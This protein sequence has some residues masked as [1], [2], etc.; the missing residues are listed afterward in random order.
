MS[1]F[2]ELIKN[3][4]KT[5]DYMRDF[6]VF[7]YKTRS[8]FQL[9]SPRTYDN[10]KRRIESWLGDLIQFD[11]TKK[12][13]QVSISLDSRQLSTNP[14]YKAYKSKSF[15]N[16]DIKLHFFLLDLLNGSEPLSV[17]DI[18]D[19][20]CNTY[21]EY[22]EPQTI[23]LKLREYVSEGIISQTKCGKAY[24]YKLSEM[25]PDTLCSRYKDFPEMLGFFSEVAP[26]GVVGSFL[27]DQLNLKNGTF[28]FKHPFIVHTLEDNILLQLIKAID[29]KRV[30]E[31]VNFSKKLKQTIIRATPLKIYVST[32]TGRRYVVMYLPF[33]KRFT[34]FRLDNIKSVKALETDDNFDEYT[35]NLHKNAPMCWGVSFGTVRCSEQS[36][37]FRMIL[38]IDEKNERDVLERLLREKRNGMVERIDKNTFAYSTSIFDTNEMM[39]WV[40]TFIG[41]IVSLEGANLPV[42]QK[43]HHDIERMKHL[44]EEV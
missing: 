31:I 26:F 37:S 38:H 29:E 27:M 10:E 40:K 5:R 32:Q 25:F 41:R 39:N 28:I 22:F 14:L 8:D 16:N 15:T 11:T 12:G 17:D 34:A 1:E 4:D 9:K 21:K 30:V 19:L 43:F 23:R 44:Y 2:S 35:N 18:T 42:I 33:T 24:Q 13:K 20:I 6:F 7:G 3:F 36:E